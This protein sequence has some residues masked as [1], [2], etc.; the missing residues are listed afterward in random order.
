MDGDGPR[1]A[2]NGFGRIGRLVTRILLAGE[3]PVDLVGINDPTE[4]H[5][6]AHLIESCEGNH[7]PD[8]PIL[9]ELTGGAAAN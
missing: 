4:R 7:R 3:Q 1:I 2:I 9:D 6:L 8:C 5:T